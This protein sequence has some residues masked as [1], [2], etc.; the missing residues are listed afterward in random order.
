MSLLPN[1]TYFDSHYL[2]AEDQWFSSGN[3][4]CIHH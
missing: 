2:L 3:S 1:V 4:V